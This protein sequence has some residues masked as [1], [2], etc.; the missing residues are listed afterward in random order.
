MKTIIDGSGLKE[1]SSGGESVEVSTLAEFTARTQFTG[2]TRFKGNLTGALPGQLTANSVSGSSVSLTNPGLHT[3]YTFVDVTA[4]LPA[5]SAF[6]GSM[7]MIASSGGTEVFR[8][9]GSTSVS[10]NQTVFAGSLSGSTTGMSSQGQGSGLS[11]AGGWIML[12]SSGYRYHILS[13]SGTVT[14]NPAT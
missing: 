7:W 5:A 3:L 13:V 10:P 9:T 2:S 11:V 8:L 12:V 1:D 4:S 6:P 14:F